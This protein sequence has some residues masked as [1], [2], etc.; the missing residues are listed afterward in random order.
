MIKLKDIL[1]TSGPLREGI[2]DRFKK[3]PV[4]VKDSKASARDL[5]KVISDDEEKDT[6]AAFRSPDPQDQITD[7]VRFFIYDYKKSKFKPGKDPAKAYDEARK[8]YNKR[9]TITV[10]AIGELVA[11]HFVK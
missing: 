3:K 11:K 1:G 10:K 9:K 4:T 8:L 5:N 6:P 7:W 2:F